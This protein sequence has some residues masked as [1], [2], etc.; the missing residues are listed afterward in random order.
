MPPSYTG[1][2]D[3]IPGKSDG[4]VVPSYKVQYLVAP[5]DRSFLNF[6][7]TQFI[8]EGVTVYVDSRKERLIRCLCIPEN[9]A[10]IK[11]ID[12]TA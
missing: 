4:Q 10:R 5:S 9:V 12:T 3:S 1:I 2:S 6:I 7:A 8:Q 11:A